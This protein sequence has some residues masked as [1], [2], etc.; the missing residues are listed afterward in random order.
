MPALLV[1]VALTAL[2]AWGGEG[3][4]SG[5]AGN[6]APGGGSK[7]QSRPRNEAGAAPGA[8]VETGPRSVPEFQPAF[9]GQ[10]RAP[11]VETKSAFQVT[12]IA[13]GFDKP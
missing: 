13:D 5:Q 12:E 6:L 7:E 4:D 8:P 3:Q 1:T 2:I 11:A 10:T 9:P